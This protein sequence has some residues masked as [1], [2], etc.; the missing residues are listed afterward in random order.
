MSFITKKV[1]TQTLGEFLQS[2]RNRLGLGVAEIARLTKIQPKYLAALEAG[3][4]QALPAPVYVKGFLKTLADVYRAD[5]DW[6]LREFL[7]EAS[8]QDNLAATG[9][10]KKESTAMPGFILSPKTLMIF[11]IGALGIISLAYLYFQVSSL[12]RG[13]A[14]EI[15]SPEADASVD[16]GLLV[17]SGKS[18]P[19]A[20][21]YLNNQLIV[22]D[23]EG[24]FRENISLGP[25]T[26]QLIIKAVNKFDRETVVARSI[27]FVPK[28]IAG[29]FTASSSA[30]V[31]VEVSVGP[32]VA[33]VYLEADGVEQY[34]GTMFP[35]SSKMITAQSRVVLTT[36]NAGSTRVMWNGKNVG[37]LGKE[38]EVIRNIEFGR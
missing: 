32:G 10:S 36:S 19:G 31:L 5:P 23:T 14:L 3:H 34:A 22:A 30:P 16:S 9:Q 24:N 4:W 7:A 15:F 21:V 28:E 17:V 18:E 12:N 33:W 13:P 1:K 25:G 2:R 8:I 6:M 38:A 27:V 11:G 20:S 29:S 35:N 37:V 26:N